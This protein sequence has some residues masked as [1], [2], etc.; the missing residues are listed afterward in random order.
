MRINK[1]EN[2]VEFNNVFR[3]KTNI[4]EEQQTIKVNK[5][6]F[7]NSNSKGDFMA[8]NDINDLETLHQKGKGV[9]E[10]LL[11]VIKDK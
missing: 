10:K 9:A 8:I 3:A 4:N 1:K 2:S 7:S 5:L 11:K 6:S